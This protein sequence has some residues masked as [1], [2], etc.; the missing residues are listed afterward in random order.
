MPSL[1]FVMSAWDAQTVVDLL[2]GLVRHNE[3]CLRRA[4]RPLLYDS[5]VVYRQEPPGAED[6]IDVDAVLAAGWGDCE[7]LAAWRAAELRVRG[8]PA[9]DGQPGQV[10]A[11]LFLRDFNGHDY[12]AVV[13]VLVDGQRI[14]E[15]PSALLGMHGSID[16]TIARRRGLPPAPTARL[17]RVRSTP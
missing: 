12:H 8:R 2:N 5:H 16:P 17:K 4:P 15:D 11:N 7:D 3:A 6:M 13:E 14:V 9:W 1:R 10:Q